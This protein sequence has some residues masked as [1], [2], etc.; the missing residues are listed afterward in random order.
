MD[1]K[2]A[3]IGWANNLSVK[4]YTA[5]PVLMKECK[6]KRDCNSVY[7]TSLDNEGRNNGCQFERYANFIS[8]YKFGQFQYKAYQANCSHYFSYTDPSILVFKIWLYLGESMP[9][10]RILNIK[11]KHVVGEGCFQFCL[12]V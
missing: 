10:K 3:K 4:A 9:V 12:A 6:H 7:G 5:S 11:C 1:R 2:L 8:K